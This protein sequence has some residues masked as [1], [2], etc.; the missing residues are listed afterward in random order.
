M[1]TCWMQ[2]NTP[3]M[4]GMMAASPDGNGFQA[5]FE[6]SRLSTCQTKDGWNG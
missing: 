2:D 1:R 3:M 6:H 5:K 4:V